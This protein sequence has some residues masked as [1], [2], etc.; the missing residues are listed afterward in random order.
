MKKS[1]IRLHSAAAVAVAALA[2]A[3]SSDSVVEV[4]E[5]TPGKAEKVTLVA[6]QPGGGTRVG[7]TKEEDGTGKAYWQEGDAIGVWSNGD[8]KFSSFGIASGAGEATATFSGTVTDGVG[9]YAVYP[10]NEKH[11]IQD[12]ALTYYLPEKYTYTSVDQTV[13]PEG[14]DGNSFNMPMLG[15]ITDGQTVSFSH[16]AGVFCLKIDKMPAGSGT[17]I[18]T[19]SGK[20]LCGAFTASLAD[21]NPEITTTTS[22]TDNAVTFVYSGAV[23]DKPGI[24]YLPAA[25]G[26]YTL[27]VAVSGDKKFSTTTHE[28]KM[29]RGGLQVVNVTTEY[30]SATTN[31]DGTYTINGHKFIDLGLP[32]GLLWAETNIGATAACDDGNYYAWGETA[33]KSD[34]S[35]ATYTTALAKYENGALLYTKYTT[36]DGK[37]VLDPEDDAAYV[38]WGS[39]C[40]MPTKDE[41]QELISNC[42]WDEVKETN[43]AGQ[44]IYCHK[45]KSNNNGNIIYLPNSG[46]RSGGSLCNYGSSY[47]CSGQY[48]SSTLYNVGKARLLRFAT[49]LRYVDYS[50]YRYGRPVRSVAEP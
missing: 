6:N 38:N 7:F 35:D 29:V 14:K 17:V 36:T 8:G 32:S 24:F 45:L 16:L 4:P 1:N 41:F 42:T 50:P 18:V 3:C 22:E 10:Y 20:Q 39:G 44:T 5:N 2:S 46:Y 30:T 26:S 12:N 11:G 34:Y 15:K 21:T 23:A 49:N 43:S 31:D 40:R 13:S 48:W 33:P 9:K 27:T 37:T 25:T 47:D 28:V 19:S